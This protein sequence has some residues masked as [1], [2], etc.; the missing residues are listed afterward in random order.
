M[1]IETEKSRLAV[2]LHAKRPLDLYFFLLVVID[3]KQAHEA[4][5]ENRSRDQSEDKVQH[6]D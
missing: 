2:F 3:L 4:Y 6:S 1:R 5:A